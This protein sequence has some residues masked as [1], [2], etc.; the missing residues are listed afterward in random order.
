MSIFDFG[1]PMCSFCPAPADLYTRD[2]YYCIDCDEALS[3]QLER[4]SA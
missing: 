2:H 3:I 1:T 4:K